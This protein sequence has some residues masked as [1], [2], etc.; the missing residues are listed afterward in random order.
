[1]LFI[2]NIVMAQLVQ[3]VGGDTGFYIGRYHVEYVSCEAAGYTHFGNFV[4]RF[5]GYG[6]VILSLFSVT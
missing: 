2:H 6:H 3:C 4:G 5:N 1:M